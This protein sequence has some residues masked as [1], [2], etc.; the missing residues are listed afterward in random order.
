MIKYFLKNDYLKNILT[1]VGG[2]FFTQLLTILLSP[3]LTR[4]YSPDTFGIIAVFLSIVNVLSVIVTLRYESVIVIIDNDEE[5][6]SLM[7]YLCFFIIFFASFFSLVIVITHL[8][9]YLIFFQEEYLLWIYF[10]PLVIS[11]NAFFYIFRN[12]LNRKKQFKG[13]SLAGIYKSLTLNSLLVLGGFWSPTPWIFLMSNLAAQAIETLFLYFKIYQL[14]GGIFNGFN[15][16]L[17][18]E[19]LKNFKNFPKYSLPA[20]IINVY[21]SQNPIV[22]LTIFYGFTP[23]GFFSITQRVLGLPLKLISSS[24]LEVFKQKASE[25][26]V[27]KGSCT[28]IFVKTFKYLAITAIIP[29]ILIAT[30]SPIIFELV[31]GLEWIQAGYFARYLSVMFFFQ[32][33][34]SPLGFTLLISGKQKLNLIWQIGLLS[35]TTLGLYLGYLSNSVDKSVFF[36][37]IS[38]SLMYIIYFF[39][40][41]SSTTKKI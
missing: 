21:T 22:L 33:T 8:D 17:G 29:T 3:V 27:T 7:G 18:L 15:K 12:W 37:S 1:I 24:T 2:V 5:A 10:I 25:D 9:L 19:A 16:F 13:I 23:V 41:Y 31:F 28:E 20:D 38:Y 35:I 11:L 14:D 40:S 34:V 26:F 4:L 32:F 36:Y 30:F 39:I 6:K